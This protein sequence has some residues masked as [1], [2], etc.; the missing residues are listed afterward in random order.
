MHTPVITEAIFGGERRVYEFPNGFGASVVRHEYS[1]GGKDGRWE[2][3]VLDADGSLTYETPVTS[4]VIGWLSD[5]EVQSK[6][7]EISSLTPAVIAWHKAE[8]E[9][10]A[11]QA[12]I[13]ELREELARLESEV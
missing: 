12:R 8:S 3:A 1:Y 5:E 6:L 2:I 11:R 9:R 10:E 13:A 7:D 4:D